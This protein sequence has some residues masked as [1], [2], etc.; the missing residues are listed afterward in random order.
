MHRAKWLIFTAII[1]G[2]AVATA[3][4]SP[5][6]RQAK[7][8]PTTLRSL[9]SVSPP[10]QF[11]RAK[12]ALLLVDFQRE[13]VDGR[14]PLPE[15]PA[16]SKARRRARAL[17]APIG[18]ARGRGQK[19]RRPSGESGLRTRLTEQRLHHRAQPPSR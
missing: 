18:D 5:Q 8:A 13:F 16:G 12:T 14:L 15:G 11:Q 4:Q 19:Y 6:P 17:G 2:A 7:V 9:Y 10:S 1:A 3:A